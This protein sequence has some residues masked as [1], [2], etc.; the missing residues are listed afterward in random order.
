MA[1]KSVTEVGNGAYD[2]LAGPELVE[3]SLRRPRITRGRCGPFVATLMA[4]AVIV[5]SCKSS[6][7][8]E[9][10]AGQTAP[11][12][13]DA[14]SKE[15]EAIRPPSEPRERRVGPAV[16]VLDS[17]SK[18]LFE[19]DTG[20]ERFRGPS[21]LIDLLERRRVTLPGY[22]F[23]VAKNFPQALLVSKGRLY[24]GSGLDGNVVEVMYHQNELAIAREIVLPP[25]LVTI[26]GQTERFLN[27]DA[28]TGTPFVSLLSEYGEDHLLAVAVE[29]TSVTSVGYLIER[30]SGRVRAARQLP[31]GLAANAVARYRDGAVAAMSSKKLVVLRPDLSAERELAVP[32]NPAYLEVRGDTA[33][34]ALIEPTKL[35]S[36]D[37]RSGKVEDLAQ[38]PTEK[39]G[40]PVMT[41]GSTA[42]WAHP[43]DGSIT[44]VDLQKRKVVRTVKACEGGNSM[45]AFRGS[46]YMTCSGGRALAVINAS[47][48]GRPAVRLF[49]VDGMPVAVAPPLVA[50]G[51]TEGAVR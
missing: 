17:A 41:L 34:V 45:I 14:A 5:T 10:V 24:V 21:P 29:Y 40:G 36:V 42:W 20:R 30:H 48:S 9:P 23:P 22:P 39:L 13:A 4:F 15:T 44:I 3:G 8:S 50:G 7:R 1:T 11:P 32:G 26:E 27:A 38:H 2:L 47:S 51:N 37:L 18:S 46:V 33:L 6:P 16:L 43:N 12:S 31:G 49:T 28:D 35:V 19:F 25:Q